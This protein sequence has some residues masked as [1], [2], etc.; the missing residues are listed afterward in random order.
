MVERV[1]SYEVNLKA[2]VNF[3]PKI[4]FQEEKRKAQMSV[5]AFVQL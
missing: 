4:I 5:W 2:E 3:W 1:G